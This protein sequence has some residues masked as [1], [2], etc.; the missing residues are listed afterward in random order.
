MSQGL[1]MQPA[2]DPSLVSHYITDAY[3]RELVDVFKNWQRDDLLIADPAERDT[4]RELLEREARLL[5]RLAFDEWLAAGV[6]GWPSWGAAEA[7]G[8]GPPRGAGASV[9]RRP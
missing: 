3:Y 5:D 1:P 4:F 8:G 7:G 2:H 6:P 9:G